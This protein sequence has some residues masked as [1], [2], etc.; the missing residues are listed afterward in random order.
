MGA[1]VCVSPTRSGLLQRRVRVVVDP[2]AHEF[3]TGAAGV[4]S[5]AGR[6]G[7]LCAGHGT[8]HCPQQPETVRSGSKDGLWNSAGGPLPTGP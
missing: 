3:S 7:L 1:S 5:E 8:T 4:D 2:G 6:R